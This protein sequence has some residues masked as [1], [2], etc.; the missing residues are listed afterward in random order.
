VELS[1]HDLEARVSVEPGAESLDLSLD[2]RIDASLVL[3]PR[4]IACTTSLL[5]SELGIAPDREPLLLAI[6]AVLPEPTLGARRGNLQ[7]E[8]SSIGEANT[9][10]T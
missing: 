4:V 10:F 7:I 6:E 8:A 2:Y 1:G 9:R 5:Q 3:L